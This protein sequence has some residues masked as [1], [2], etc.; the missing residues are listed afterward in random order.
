MYKIE[1]QTWGFKLTFADFIKADEMEEWKNESEA[2]LKAQTGEF[3]VFVDMRV[4]KTLP[5]DSKTVMEKG[6]A[7]YKE[8]GMTRSVVILDSATVT[9]QF[10]MIA[11]QSG[12]YQ[13]ERYIDASTKSDWEKIGLDWIVKGIDPDK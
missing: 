5:Q 13:W 9:M 4:L 11:K 7:L 1:K 8:K 3:G 10:K 12:I 6:Q 2:A